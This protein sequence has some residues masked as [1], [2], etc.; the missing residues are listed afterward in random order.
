VWKSNVSGIQLT[1]ATKLNTEVRKLKEQNTKLITDTA[2][3]R[4]HGIH[5]VLPTDIVAE[6]SSYFCHPQSHHS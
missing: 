2:K 5:Q 1:S 6:Y 3:V 4:P